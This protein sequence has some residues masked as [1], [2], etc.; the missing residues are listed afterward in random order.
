MAI[1]GTETRDLQIIAREAIESAMAIRYVMLEDIQK[2]L[3]DQQLPVFNFRIGVD[4]GE[5][6]ISRI[7]I[8]NMN[9][10]TVVGDAANRASKL[11]ALSRTN[12][13]AIG[14]NLATNL[15]SFLDQY[16]EEGS[17][18]SWL[19]KKEASDEP[20]RFFHYNLNFLAPKEWL[21]IKFN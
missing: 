1:L 21:K 3:G 15:D 2:I 8:K 4:M 9:F 18:P 12:G 20:Y 13:I 5:V 10:I 11:Q 7:G 14:E 6:L 19:W 17:D 16:M